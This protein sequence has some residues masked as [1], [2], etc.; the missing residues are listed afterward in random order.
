MKNKS[1]NQKKKEYHGMKKVADMNYYELLDI[2]PS[3]TNEE[4]QKAYKQACQTYQPDSLALY[5][6]LSEEDRAQMQDRTEKA[7]RTLMDEDERQKYDH[8]LG[9]I[10]NWQTNKEG[11]ETEDFAQVEPNNQSKDFPGESIDNNHQEKPTPELSD[12]QYLKKLRERKGISLQEISEVTNISVSS[13]LALENTEYEKIPGRVYLVG[14]L[15]SYAEFI[16]I[17][18]QQAKAHFEIFYANIGKHK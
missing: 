11:T 6:L 16:G 10:S 12:P 5:S 14:F 17:D 7:Y 1:E 3:A 9:V 4:I 8:Q 18:F 15:R 13:L 2:E